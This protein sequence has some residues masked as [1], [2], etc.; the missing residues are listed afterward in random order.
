MM[1]FFNVQN[2]TPMSKISLDEMEVVGKEQ[3][4]QSKEE[5]GGD[6]HSGDEV[7]QRY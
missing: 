6:D 3:K 4:E 2:D 5:E 1:K 7:N